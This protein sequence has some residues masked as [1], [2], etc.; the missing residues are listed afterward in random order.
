M[1][2]TKRRFAGMRSAEVKIFNNVYLLSLL[3]TLVSQT[4]KYLTLRY[5]EHL[6]IKFFYILEN[7]RIDSI[8]SSFPEAVCTIQFVKLI[9]TLQI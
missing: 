1:E 6:E 8:L 3:E 2:N 7:K 5:F 4:K 9:G